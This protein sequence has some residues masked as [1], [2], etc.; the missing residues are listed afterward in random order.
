MPVDGVCINSLKTI[1]VCAIGCETWT[2]QWKATCQITHIYIY[3]YMFVISPSMAQSVGY[4][5]KSVRKIEDVIPT[6]FNKLAG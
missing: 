2:V 3:I 5:M 4:D 6:I 1:L